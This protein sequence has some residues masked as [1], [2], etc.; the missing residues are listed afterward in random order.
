MAPKISK[1]ASSSS[2]DT[3]AG[4]GDLTDTCGKRTNKGE[5]GSDLLRLN[6]ATLTRIG[7][8]M[9][10]KLD[11]TKK[12]MVSE[13]LPGL[14]RCSEVL[15]CGAGASGSGDVP[16]DQDGDKDTGKDEDGN[17]D[18][19]GDKDGSEGEQ[20]EDDGFQIFVQMQTGKTITLGAM[21]SDTINVV[22]A[23][24]QSKEGIPRTHQRL[25]FADN[26]LENGR[27]LS[28]Y[29]IQNDSTLILVLRIEGSGKRGRQV[30]DRKSVV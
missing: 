6:I 9:G 27:T 10:L 3:G 29:N 20:S 17:A 26:H 8:L 14:L 30:A 12:S 28:H 2:A 4:V 23:L 22:K 5:I 7:L 24:V 21:A 19:D 16:G 18:Q 11:G 1:V 25:I 15:E 13:L